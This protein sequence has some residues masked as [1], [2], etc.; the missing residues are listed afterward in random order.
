MNASWSAVQELQR[1]GLE[2]EDIELITLE[3]PVEYESAKKLVP[4]L[5][6]EYDP[7]VC[8]S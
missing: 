1:L 4:Q 2:D 6:K 8:C 3:V 5:W 7:C